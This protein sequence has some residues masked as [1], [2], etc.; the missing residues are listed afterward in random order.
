MSTP[1]TMG[2]LEYAQGNHPLMTSNGFGITS[3]GTC[4]FT[5]LMC[6]IMMQF[7]GTLIFRLD[8][9]LAELSLGAGGM[10]P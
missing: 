10:C 8:I 2:S 5:T 7:S 3:R 4:D 6:C 9:Y 1:V